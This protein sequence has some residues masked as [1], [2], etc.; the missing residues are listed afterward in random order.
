MMSIYS[1]VCWIY[2]PRHSDHL[3]YPSITVPPLSLL[4]DVLGGRDWA[5]LEMHLEAVI[6][7]I[8]RYTWRLRSSELRDGL[9]GR[10]WASIEIHLEAEI[11]W[12]QRCTWR[13]G[14]SEFGNTLRGQDRVISEMHS[15]AAMERVWRCTDARMEWTQRCIWRPSSIKIGGV[16]GGGWSGG[17]WYEGGQSGGSE[18]GG[19][20][21]GGMCDGS[22]DSIHWSTRNCGNVEIWV[23]HSLLRAERLAGSGRQSIL[24]WCSTRCMQYSVNTVLGVC[25]SR[26]MQYSVYA[27]LGVCCTRCQLLIMAWRDREEWHNFVFLGDGRVEDEKERDERRWATHHEELGWKRLSCE[28]QFTIP[29]KAGTSSDLACNNTD[30]RS[31]QPH[32]AS[33]TPDFS[34]SLLSSK[35]F[36]S[37]S[38]ISLFLIHYHHRRTQ[39]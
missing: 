25:C 14:S 19:A 5:S 2:T 34:Y 35:S 11:E 23:Q 24:G 12:T 10:D 29:N 39:S 28:S 7:S 3:R 4:E 37:S 16:L 20:R 30:M 8:W 9:E 21:S 18:S 38:P 31:F 13:P 32:Q 26:C 17:D 22:S 27:V 36:S 15:E 1:R 6:E 33:R